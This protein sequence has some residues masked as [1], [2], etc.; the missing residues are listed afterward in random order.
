MYFG[1]ELPL[2]S[3][4]LELSD[5]KGCVNNDLLWYAIT[6]VTDQ[7]LRTSLSEDA[8]GKQVQN[9]KNAQNG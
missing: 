2:S 8:Y 5:S 9:M 1:Q 6:G 4:I 3:V 7:Y